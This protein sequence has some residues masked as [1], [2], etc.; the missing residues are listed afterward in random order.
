MTRRV[1]MVI[2]H[3][4]DP[5]ADFVV[6]ELNR[7]GVAVLRLDTADFPLR[8]TVTGCLGG[9]G[10]SG[11]IRHA[12]RAVCLADIAGIYFRRPTSFEFGAMPD[13][14]QAWALAEARCGLG[15][16][17][18]AHERWLNHPHHIGYADYKPVQLAAA[19]R[20]GLC[21]PA[22]I[23]TNDPAQ[24]RAFADPPGQVIYKQLSAEPPP[25]P[26]DAATIYTSVTEPD[27]LAADGDSIAA[28]MHLFQELIVSQ[29]ALR[30]TVVDGLMFAAAIR[31][32][33]RAAALDWRADQQALTYQVVQV[34]AAVERAVLD[35]MTALHLR[36]GALDFLVTPDGQWVFL[37]INANGQW[38]FIEQATGLPIAAA[39]AD[40]LTT[41]GAP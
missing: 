22:T 11:T 38:A 5:T 41:T 14:A 35:L 17:L 28:T 21:V 8:L 15:G 7:R 10:W 37:E 27:H 33:S 6:E 36:F 24:A 30:L 4:F 18:M 34:P 40:A 25:G 29:Y 12:E 31:P 1:V 3:W 23:L 2:T 9:P 20:A 13:E 39:I 19:A 26:G 16:L 32:H